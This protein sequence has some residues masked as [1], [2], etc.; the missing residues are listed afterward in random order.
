MADTF[1]GQLFDVAP[2]DLFLPQLS[3]LLVETQSQ[4][5]IRCPAP[6]LL[7]T[8]HGYFPLFPQPVPNQGCYSMMR[9]QRQN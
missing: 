7:C 5:C 6:C 8:Q 4:V 2:Q 9:C 3:L 1:L